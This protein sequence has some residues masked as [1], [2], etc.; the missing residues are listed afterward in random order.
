MIA[1]L[2]PDL[3]SIP[4]W[5]RRTAQGQYLIEE[6]R[7]ELL[8]RR[9]EAVAEM[10]R[11]QADAADKAPKLHAARDLARKKYLDAQAAV[12]RALA[13]YRV[14]DT[15]VANLTART[16]LA[17]SEQRK[18]LYDTFPK[19][20]DA[21]LAEL[22]QLDNKARHVLTEYS[23][24]TVINADPFQ[25]S[26]V[27]LHAL[28]ERSRPAAALTDLIRDTMKRVAALRYEAAIDVEST[29]AGY[30]LAIREAAAK[31]GADL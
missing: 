19:E 20:I 11:L 16:E 3:K 6:Q 10:Q 18:F 2:L 1:D 15:A 14:A 5:F 30:R 31:A 13:E 28:W 24:P 27:T 25:P 9:E 8:G 12:Q 29:I 7:R 17:M 21:Y 4:D 23:G 22:R 26:A